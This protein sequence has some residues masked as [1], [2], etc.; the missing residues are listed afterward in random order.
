M[1][2]HARPQQ[3]R[4]RLDGHEARPL[5]VVPL[6]ASVGAGGVHTACTTQRVHHIDCT[7]Q[8]AWHSLQRT[9]LVPD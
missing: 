6:V 9:Q 5:T 1:E 8:F 2:L 7:T 4:M 3:A